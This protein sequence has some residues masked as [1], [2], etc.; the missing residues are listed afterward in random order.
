M[1]EI[2][3]VLLSYRY[4]RNDTVHRGEPDSYDQ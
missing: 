3:I 4:A 2:N 1:E